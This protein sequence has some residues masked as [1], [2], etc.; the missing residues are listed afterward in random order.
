MFDQ[1]AYKKNT[2]IGVTA[3]ILKMGGAIWF[4]CIFININLS[5]EG[6]GAKVL[7]LLNGYHE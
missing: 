6:W 3:F 7:S 4:S 1:L 2:L 5:M